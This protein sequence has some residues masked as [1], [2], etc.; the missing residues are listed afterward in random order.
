MPS[1]ESDIAVMKSDINYIKDDI[2][3]IKDAVKT[4]T[5]ELPKKA[6]RSELECKADKTD[7]T[8]IGKA[9]GLQRILT[10][11]L[12]GAT[13]AVLVSLITYWIMTKK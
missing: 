11:V 5:N 8:N 6:N 2:K 13:T 1:N 4:I 12:V 9:N 10:N 7:L 3:E